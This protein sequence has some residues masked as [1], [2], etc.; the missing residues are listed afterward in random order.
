MKVWV[1]LVISVSMRL[2]HWATW[3]TTKKS[4]HEGIIYPCDQCE[5]AAT[6]LSHLKNHKKSNHE[7]IRYPCD[8]CDYKFADLSNLRKQQKLKYE[9]IRYPCDQC[10]YL[11]TR[12]IYLKRHKKNIKKSDIPVIS[13]N[14]QL[15]YSNLKRHKE[16]NHK[17]LENPCDPSIFTTVCPTKLNMQSES[18]GKIISRC[19]VC[20]FRKSESRD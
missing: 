5:Y 6:S 10:E 11:T 15:L 12:P 14:I 3:K 13:V 8:Q 4:K 19:F 2:L 16:S 20:P 1:I 9:G 7:V 17:T 18:D